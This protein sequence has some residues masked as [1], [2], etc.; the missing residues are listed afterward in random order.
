MRRLHPDKCLQSTV[1]TPHKTKTYRSRTPR[2]TPC[3]TP[4]LRALR[5]HTA[6]LRIRHSLRM[7]L[8]R[9]GCRIPYSSPRRLSPYNRENRRDHRGR[10]TT[11]PHSRYRSHTAFRRQ[12]MPPPGS[13]THRVRRRTREVKVHKSQDRT[14][15]RHRHREAGCTLSKACLPY[16]SCPHRFQER[17]GYPTYWSLVNHRTQTN[18]QS[19]RST[20]TR[21]GWTSSFRRRLWL[22]HPPAQ[23]LP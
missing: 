7:H 4:S 21:T 19:P 13:P 9:R 3:R 23:A 22:P 6:M 12:C 16:P 1:H 18:H 20:M 10:R 8:Y 2:R 5:H 15:T 17:Q 11:P 14:R